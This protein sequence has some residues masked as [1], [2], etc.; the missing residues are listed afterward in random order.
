[1]VLFHFALYLLSVYSST[2]VKPEVESKLDAS[3]DMKSSQSLSDSDEDLYLFEGGDA[4]ISEVFDLKD[5]VIWRFRIV[6][7]RPKEDAKDTSAI[8][9]S[10][11]L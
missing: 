3:A 5:G 4:Q 6:Q 8:V 11:A 7:R 10:K 1:M 9:N 2:S